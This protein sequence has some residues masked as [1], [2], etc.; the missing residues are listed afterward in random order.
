MN[1]ENL[2][3]WIVFFPLVAA[4]IILLIPAGFK[5]LIK[6]V[7]V[8]GALVTFLITQSVTSRY[9]DADSRPSQATRG[10]D[11]VLAEM[12]AQALAGLEAPL[13]E[14]IR[15]VLP[16]A[17]QP[18]RVLTDAEK[19]SLGSG[20]LREWE[21]LAELTYASQVPTA[22]TLRFV[23]FY[24][25]IPG[26]DVNYF[27]AVDGLSL[28]LVWLT[29][30][31]GVLCLVYSWTIEKGT[32]AYFIL[33]LV[34]ETGLLGVFLALDFFLFYVFW[35]IVLL[36]MYFLIGVWGGPN[37][38]YAAIK[39]FIYTLVGSVVMLLV[40]LVMYFA[41][42]PH[43]FN[44]L[45]LTSLCP[46]F[47]F[48]MQTWLFLGLFLGFAIKVP[49]F[50]FHT[51][52]PD[53]HVEAPTAV[54]V[55]LAGVLLKMGG[56]GFFRFSYSMLPDG[57]LSQGMIWFIAILGMINIV[58]GAFCAIAQKDFKKLVAYSSVSHMGYVMLGLAAFNQA[59]INGAAL[60]MFNHGV[61]S[62]MLF[63]IVGVIYD[64]AHHRD[65]NRFG[66]V[67]LEMP[68]YTGVATVGFFASLGL[69]GL[70][71]FIGEF[72]VFLGA[73][74]RNGL[75]TSP[76]GI[77]AAWIIYVSLLGV[78]L[79]A[80]YILWTIQR[81]YLGKPVEERR[82]AYHELDFREAVALVPLAVICIA[83]GIFPQ[84]TI[85]RHIDPS[86]SSMTSMVRGAAD[87]LK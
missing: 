22:K 48:Q 75:I 76:S 4:G 25:W 13:A 74:D 79:A 45:A 50:P 20:G 36:P 70:C 84:Q 21:R 51:W 34:L 23:E 65:L 66:G 29:A 52:L 61:S 37:R 42:E 85:I 53:A 30:L 67:G 54:S 10:A 26:F 72:L 33:F 71:G 5:T 62:A 12:T 77:N 31:L 78:V 57:A 14:R 6:L 15:Q 81:V 43:T 27:L 32:K 28:P 46:G 40:M 1:S 80:V 83:V 56:Y 44:V 49:I 82:H 24:E 18:P 58:Y 63:L 8:A 39:F 86:L 47:S 17:G 64:R 7:G 69:P 38:I 41:T 2:L 73:W 16:V 59:G 87:I 11:V 35:E 55:V 19:A 9:M 68:W 60:Q 3:S